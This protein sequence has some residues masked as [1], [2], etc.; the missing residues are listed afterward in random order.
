[1]RVV[2]QQLVG[3][4]WAA[5]WCGQGVTSEQLLLAAAVAGHKVEGKARLLRAGPHA[6]GAAVCRPQRILVT[7]RPA[8]SMQRQSN[9][10][11]DPALTPVLTYLITL[12]GE[13][14]PASSWAAYQSGTACGGMMPPPKP[15]LISS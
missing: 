1:M 7:C 9:L 13:R 5:G 4:T 14:R 15:T 12:Q 3:A 10:D 11:L 6:Q 8:E 2:V